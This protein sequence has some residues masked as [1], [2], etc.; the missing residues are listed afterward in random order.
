MGDQQFVGYS[1]ITWTVTD[2]GN[3]DK[4]DEVEIA[5]SE[6]QPP[7][8]VIVTNNLS[9]SYRDSDRDGEPRTSKQQLILEEDFAG[10]LI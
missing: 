10:K 8:C 7:H 3:S 5:V 2:E 9:T 1:D 6:S 4:K